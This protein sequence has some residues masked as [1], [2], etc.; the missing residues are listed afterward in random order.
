MVARGAGAPQTG[1]PLQPLIG[2]LL[3]ASL[4]FAGTAGPALAQVDGPYAANASSNTARTA[5][6]PTV[7]VRFGDHRGFSRAVFDWP[8]EVGYQVEAAAGVVRIR[9]AAAARVDGTEIRRMTPITIATIGAEVVAGATLVRLTTPPDSKIRHFRHGTKIVVDVLVPGR[10]L[11]DVALAGDAVA[12]APLS[13]APAR[14]RLS[15]APPGITTQIANNY[16]I[17]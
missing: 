17:Y 11:R 14:R 1:S 6:P 3:L 9:F 13:K 8:R 4:A 12:A 10:S 5:Q 2:L 16:H 15:N 7:L